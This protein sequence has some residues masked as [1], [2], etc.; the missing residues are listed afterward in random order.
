MSVLTTANLGFPR[1]GLHR[2]LKFALESFWSGKTGEDDLL[3]V[4]R[5]LRRRHWLLQQQAGI[6]IIPSNDFSLYDQVLDAMV[7][8]GATP[9]RYGDSHVGGVRAGLLQPCCTMVGA[10]LRPVR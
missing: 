9:A 1:M 2:E 6:S 5:D 8:V 4:A 10:G 3:A 7:L